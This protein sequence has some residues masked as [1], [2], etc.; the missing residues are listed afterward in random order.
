MTALKAANG[1][2]WPR[3]IRNGMLIRVLRAKSAKVNYSGVWMVRGVQV[4]QA[5]GFLLDLSPADQIRY[6]GEKGSFR[7]VSLETLLKCGLE[8]LKPTLCGVAQ[9]AQASSA[10]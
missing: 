1:G 4:N 5:K 2:K 10:P 3:L 7:D 8:I 6:R 9:T